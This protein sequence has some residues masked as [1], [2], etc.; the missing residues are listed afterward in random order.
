M[1]IA[2]FFLLAGAVVDKFILVLTGSKDG[3]MLLGEIETGLGV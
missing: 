1:S 3:T 2:F